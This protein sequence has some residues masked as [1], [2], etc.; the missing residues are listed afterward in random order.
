MARTVVAG[1]ELGAVTTCSTA[2]G[3]AARRTHS[4]VLRHSVVMLMG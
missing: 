4:V 1:E 3:A 2:P